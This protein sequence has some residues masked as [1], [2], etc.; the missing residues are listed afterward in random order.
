MP[1]LREREQ[2]L[3]DLPQ[4]AREELAA[5]EQEIDLLLTTIARLSGMERTTISVERED[6]G[7]EPIRQ[8]IPEDTGVDFDL[9]NGTRLT[10]SRDKNSLRVVEKT[11]TSQIL[12]VPVTTGVVHIGVL[13]QK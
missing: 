13:H 9:P 1:R 2:R 11:D 4:W 8:Y 5:A 12:V 3:L 7:G 6:P 10:V